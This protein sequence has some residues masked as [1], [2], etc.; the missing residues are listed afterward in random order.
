MRRVCASCSH[1]SQ[2]RRRSN[3]NPSERFANE[4]LGSFCAFR[5]SVNPRQ[6]SS[7]PVNQ[8]QRCSPE[9]GLFCTFASSLGI[10]F[11][12]RICFRFRNWVYFAHFDVSFKDEAQKATKRL[13]AF[14]TWLGRPARA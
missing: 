2:K 5:L 6:P 10:G 12:L 1:R 13:V 8:R 11:V 9:L 7:T 3:L 14:L 4:H